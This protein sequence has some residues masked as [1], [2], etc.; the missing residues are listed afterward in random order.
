MLEKGGESGVP[1]RSAHVAVTIDSVS[2][3]G[4]A[5]IG[6]FEQRLETDEGL[7]MQTPGEMS[8]RHMTQ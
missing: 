6:V 4:L 1:G 5:R 2:T 8:P 3:V 7:P